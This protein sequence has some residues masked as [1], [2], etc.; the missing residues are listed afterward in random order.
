MI[1]NTQD[2]DTQGVYECMATSTT[3]SAK[4]R[5]AKIKSKKSVHKSRPR[6]TLAP[7][8]QNV[9]E[10]MSVKLNCE[11]VGVPEPEVTWM[12]NDRPLTLTQ[13]HEVQFVK[14]PLVETV[15]INCLCVSAFSERI[16]I[17]KKCRK[18]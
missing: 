11:A 18:R 16:P 14:T 3:G 7:S 5:S 9:N 10:G 2:Q 15:G 4:S 17:D 12:L 1:A 13:R 8:D 6:F